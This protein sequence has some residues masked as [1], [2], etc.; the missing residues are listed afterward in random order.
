MIDILNE[1]LILSFIEKLIENPILMLF[2][3]QWGFG[4]YLK[5][6][7]NLNNK[8]IPLILFAVGGTLGVG[9][10]SFDILNNILVGIIITMAQIGA[11]EG[12]KEFISFKKDKEKNKVKL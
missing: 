9:L 11:F 4:W 8:L 1:N 12:V 2:A 3:F 10:L 5:N 6:K 7:T